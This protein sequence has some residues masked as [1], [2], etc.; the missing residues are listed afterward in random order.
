MAELKLK[1]PIKIDGEE[2]TVIEYDFEELTG[3]DCQQAT[4]EL[5]KAGI[6]VIGA[7]EL[8]TN[9]HAALFAAASGI[10]F[11]DMSRL[12]FSD[13]TKATTLVRDFFLADMAE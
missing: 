9:Y 8:D 4:K 2:K 1:K 12:S 7:V 5:Q 11:A 13:Y 3:N 10:S 6:A